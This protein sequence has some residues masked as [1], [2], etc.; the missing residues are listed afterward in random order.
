MFRLSPM[1][2]CSKTEA[3][4]NICCAFVDGSKIRGNASIKNTWTKE[5]CQQALERAENRIEEVI[6]EAETIDAEEAGEP[7][8]VK[9]CK[10]LEDAR[11]LK[12]K[13]V[14]IIEE[15]KQ[16]D[17][18]NLNT[19]DKDCTRINSFQGTGA[20]YNAQVVVDDKNGL[21][22][23]C[24]AINANNDLGQFSIQVNQAK[25]VLGKSPQAAVADSGY[26]Y[27]ED[28]AKIDK[29]QIQIIVPTQRL[30]SGKEIGEFDKRN[31]RYDAGKDCYFCPRDDELVYDGLNR[32]RH[33]KVYKIKDAE[34]CLRC[35][36]FGKCTTRDEPVEGHVLTD[37][38]ADPCVCPNISIGSVLRHPPFRRGFEDTLFS[39][40]VV[41]IAIS[42]LSPGGLHKDTR[43]L[44]TNDL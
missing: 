20:G 25:E 6:A 12:Q 10:E 43:P 18:K 41:L 37:V 2:C 33:G 38:G 16:S 32:K 27:T 15:L 21:I 31:F 28:L 9:V 4:F 13:V 17:K 29:Q 40:F 36:A 14:Q 35:P 3:R 11:N 39:F 30:A 24:D 19:V 23:S 1:L 42:L 44:Y 5:K 34:T 22:I 26:A 8:L 7:S